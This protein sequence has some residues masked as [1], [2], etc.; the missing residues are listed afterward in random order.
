SKGYGHVWCPRRKRNVGAH[1]LY[2]EQ[3]HGEIPQGRH[4]DHLCRVPA[5]VNP[6]HM[7]V[8]TPAENIRRGR[9]TPLTVADV[10]LIRVASGTLDEIGARFGVT[11]QAIS[12]IRRRERWA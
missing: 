3:E 10:A 8:V 9:Q 4:I 7:E 12:R 6:A 11:K 5:C 1:R 2:W